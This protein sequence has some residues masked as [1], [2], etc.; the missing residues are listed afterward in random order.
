MNGNAGSCFCEIREGLSSGNF[1]VRF[2]C[3]EEG[4]Y[5][6]C[7]FHESREPQEDLR[8]AHFRE[9]VCKSVPARRAAAKEANTAIGFGLED[10]AL[11]QL[12]SA[13]AEA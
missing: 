5:C 6:L 9:G 1:S 10:K 7:A 11:K 3:G 12:E 4:G 2:L 13:G 8:C